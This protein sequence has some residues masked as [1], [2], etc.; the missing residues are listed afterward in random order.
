MLHT[1]E[2]V[3]SIQETMEDDSSN[4]I[5][6]IEMA[7]DQVLK[8]QSTNELPML[9]SVKIE[10]DEPICSDTRTDSIVGMKTENEQ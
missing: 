3:M 1:R 4:P 8:G 10:N 9:N 5:L 7:E 2:L 6:G